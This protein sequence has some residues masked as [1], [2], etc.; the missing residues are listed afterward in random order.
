MLL[1]VAFLPL[2]GAVADRSEAKRRLLVRG[3]A[4]GVVATLML[5]AVPLGARCPG[6]GY[7]GGG[8]LLAL[9]LLVVLFHARLGLSK[10]GAGRVAIA[11]AAL[12]WGAFGA[13]SVQRLRSVE[14]CRPA[15]SMINGT[16]TGP[17]ASLDPCWFRG[18]RGVGRRGR[19]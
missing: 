15:T 3:T 5:A 12:W 17:G 14:T 13:L 8:L 1:Q 4:V 9:D 11:S 16:S 2:L 7:A 19:A 10:S 18:S 6:W